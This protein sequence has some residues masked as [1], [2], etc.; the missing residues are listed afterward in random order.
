MFARGEFTVSIQENIIRHPGRKPADGKR[1][2]RHGR[3]V[4]KVGRNAEQIYVIAKSRPNAI[5]RIS[6]RAR[7]AHKKTTCCQQ[8][9]WRHDKIKSP[10]PAKKV[11]NLSTESVAQRASHWNRYI[12]PGQHPSSCLDR[13]KIGNDRWR[14]RSI[15]CLADPDEQSRAQQDRKGCRQSRPAAG[16]TPDRDA[17]SDQYPARKPISQPAK[18]R[19]GAH[20]TDQKSRCPK[21][22]FTILVWIAC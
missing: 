9:T 16:Q 1:H 17:D 20:V 15:T 19:R 7:F 12:K 2:Y 3:C 4:Q 11:R 18:D 6:G 14:G 5:A 10:T 13:I 8:Q 21:A 22:G